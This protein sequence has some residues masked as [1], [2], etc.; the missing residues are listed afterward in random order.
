MGVADLGAEVG[1][2]CKLPTEDFLIYDSN[3]QILPE[4]ANAVHR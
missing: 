4:P 1:V 2:F 3:P